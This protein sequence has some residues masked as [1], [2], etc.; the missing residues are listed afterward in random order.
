[1]FLSVIESRNDPP[2]QATGL[3]GAV[4]AEF[5][6]ALGLPDFEHR[7]LGLIGQRVPVGSWSVYAIGEG[8]LP[9]FIMASS[10]G[11]HDVTGD[12][13]R[14]Y[15]DEGIYRDDRSFDAARNVLHEG[16]LVMSHMKAADMPPA[17]RAAI[18]DRYRLQERLSIIAPHKDRGIVALNLYRHAD[19]APFSLSEADTIAQLA[20][21]LTAV[22]LKH[23]ALMALA[24]LSP[25]W[26][27]A[28]PMLRERY[29]RLTE[30]ELDVCAGLLQGWTFE[31]IAV[32]LGVAPATVKTYRDRA[33]RTLGISHRH[34]LY[35][36]CAGSEVKGFPVAISVD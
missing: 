33:F 27:R 23:H 8:Q 6:D 18:Y 16:R 11:R 1:M 3:T 24:G 13:W 36:V 4:M 2:G 32:H 15:R 26:G 30:R 9:Q 25:T 21:V 22:V 12:C 34:Q 28:V 31:G 7:M 17:H 19:Q 35:A 10:A 29:P 20:P 14:A 5:V